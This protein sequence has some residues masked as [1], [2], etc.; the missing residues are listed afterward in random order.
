MSASDDN[1]GAKKKPK[2][3]EIYRIW[4]L[5][6]IC[7]ICILNFSFSS[8][9]SR[10]WNPFLFLFSKVE[11]HLKNFSFSSRTLRNEIPF[12]FSSRNWRIFFSNF[13]FSSRL[14]FFASRCSVARCFK[15]NQLGNKL[16]YRQQLL[17]WRKLNF[18]DWKFSQNSHN[19]MLIAENCYHDIHQDSLFQ[20]WD[21][22]NMAA[23]RIW[24][25][26]LVGANLN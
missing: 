7:K 1:P 5:F 24:E 17:L 21:G 4:N 25:F 13:S 6:H 14:D 10:K 19:L 18:R 9:I 20:G 2:F 12:S 23:F 22:D 3:T 8:R 11:N 16:F 26:N 15:S